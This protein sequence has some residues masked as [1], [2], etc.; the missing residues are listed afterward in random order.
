LRLE[1]DA[2]MTN[3]LTRTAPYLALAITLFATRADGEPADPFSD[4]TPS[5]DSPKPDATPPFEMGE[6]SVSEKS[7]AST[8]GYAVTVPPGR[9]GMQPQLALSYSSQAPLR[10]GIAAGWSL[11][12]PVIRLDV[13]GGLDAP[14]RYVAS[15]GPSSGT[16]VPVPA[17]Y[18]LR[19]GTPYRLELDDAFTLLER[20]P[21]GHWLAMT[22]WQ[23]GSA[24]HRS[25]AVRE[26]ERGVLEEGGGGES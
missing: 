2:M 25:E 5:F 7:G 17:A 22:S 1:E 16:L 26:G 4:N 12:L 6:Y 21:A 19:G 23:R 24:A 18:A 11:D 14:P 13:S 9:Q 15:F 20:M 10:G 8:Y 3:K